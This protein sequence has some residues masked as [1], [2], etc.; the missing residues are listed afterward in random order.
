MAV[1]DPEL[2]VYGLDKL[3]VIDASVMPDVVSGNLNAP[4]IMIAEKASDMIRGKDM[5]PPSEAPIW[6]HPDW[7]KE[8]R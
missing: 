1:V 6:V 5:L 4:T 2:K 7:E 8:Q 3:R